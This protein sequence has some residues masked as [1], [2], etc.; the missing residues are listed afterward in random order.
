MTVED[1]R[2]SPALSN[3]QIGKDQRLPL[4][5]KWWKEE[6]LENIRTFLQSEVLDYAAQ[7]CKLFASASEAEKTSL[8]FP[9]KEKLN[10]AIDLLQI[11][12]ESGK[13]IKP[14]LADEAAIMMFGA[15]AS[16]YTSFAC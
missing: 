16:S 12:F 8:F 15:W 10:Q 5:E 2:W 1:I 4:F 7:Q 6:Q 9:L 14:A 13:K 11:F 3:E